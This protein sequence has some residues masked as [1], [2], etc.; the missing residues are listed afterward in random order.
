MAPSVEDQIV[1]LK[2]QLQNLEREKD[3]IN[4]RIAAKRAELYEAKQA[5]QVILQPSPSAFELYLT[6]SQ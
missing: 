3:S 2:I 4:A 5:Q 1:K 6:M